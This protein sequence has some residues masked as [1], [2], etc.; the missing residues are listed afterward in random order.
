MHDVGDG[1][2]RSRLYETLKAA[3]TEP[4]RPMTTESIYDLTFISNAG[5]SVALGRF[6]GR[7]LLIVNT[8]S[9]CG[10]T[11]QY[12]GLEALWRDYRARGL[13][14]IGFPCDQFAHQEP[15][16]NAAIEEF[17]RA[18]Y[19]IDFPLSTK[20][21]V[22]GRGTHPIFEFLKA[23]ARGRLGSAIKWNFTKFLVAPD[24]QSVKRY[25]PTTEPADIRADIEAM[26]PPDPAAPAA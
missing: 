20:I 7:P 1:I 16:D 11:P 3:I 15:G 12:E 10:F 17:C 23:H 21:E 9:R 8:A 4:S 2:R 26:L 24:G 14:V 13:V 19:G 5:E 25:A 6:E 22:N 18:N